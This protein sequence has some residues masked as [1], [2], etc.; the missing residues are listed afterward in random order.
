MNRVNKPGCNLHYVLGMLCL[1]PV[2]LNQ[3]FPECA[4]MVWR[5]LF[6]DAAVCSL[7]I[8][9]YLTHLFY[10]I[11]NGDCVHSFVVCNSST[12]WFV[13]GLM[14]LGQVTE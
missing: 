6:I 2:M 7:S 14:L 8:S 13:S 11:V 9:P 1:D 5:G 12:C 10:L 4:L 3:D